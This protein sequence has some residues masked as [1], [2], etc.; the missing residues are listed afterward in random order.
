MEP[1]RLVVD[2]GVETEF[3]H[4]VVALRFAARDTDRAAACRLGELADHAA[5]RAGGG[6][7]HH[8]FAGLRR[9]DLLHAEVGRESRHPE[10]A[11]VGGKRGAR[12]IDLG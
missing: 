3:L 2:A 10:A 5:D 9:A 12:R 1:S 4:H 7:Y 8:R 6:G 11:Q